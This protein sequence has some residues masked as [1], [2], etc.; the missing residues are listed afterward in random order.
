MTFHAR[1]PFILKRCGDETML[2]S[3]K[4]YKNSITFMDRQETL[5]VSSWYS[6]RDIAQENRG[7]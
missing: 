3:C 4:R 1:V 6:T 7:K 2:A 5:Q